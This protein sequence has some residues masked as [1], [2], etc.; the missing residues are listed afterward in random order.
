M[1]KE[2]FNEIYNKIKEYNKI[3]IITHS[4]P[5]GDAIG[6]QMGLY[7]SIKATF[8]NK[9]VYAFGEK[10]ERYGFF[11]NATEEIEDAYSG[12]LVICLDSSE[13]NMLSTTNFVNGEYIIKIDHHIEQIGYGDIKYVDTTRESCAGIIA[14]LIKETPLVMTDVAA[15]ALY[16]GMITDSGRFRYSSTTSQTFDTAS[17]LFNYNIDTNEIFNNLYVEKID[18][19]K[20]RAKLI[21]KFE[22]GKNKVAYLKNTYEEVKS[23]NTTPYSIARGM[24][25]IMAGIDGIDIWANFTEDEN[26]KILVELR[27]KAE[28]INEIAVKYGGGGHKCASGATV[29]SFEVVEKIIQDLEK[30][31]E[32]K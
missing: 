18:S 2:L 22:V 17:Y 26:G 19:V 14:D 4:K 16:T 27:S 7:Y 9:E 10:S 29:E 21:Q 32:E 1:N 31:L 12:S 13:V 6:S 24:V 30:I 5:D 11:S 8:E 15:N 23:Y 25:N 20:L 28:N 3:I